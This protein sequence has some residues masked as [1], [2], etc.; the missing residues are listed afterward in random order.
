MAKN[1]PTAEESVQ[2]FS[3]QL[4]AVI[5]AVVKEELASVETRIADAG[6]GGGSVSTDELL[7][8]PAFSKGVNDCMEKAFQTVLPQLIKRFKDEVEERF[9]DFNKGG[10]GTGNVDVKSL[11]NS[12]AMK[13]MLDGRF[14]QMLLYL[15]Q[16]IIP[17][18][19]DQKISTTA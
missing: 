8:S 7:K 1:A 6:A 17:K 16:D 9:Q 18:A 3:D 13:E 2:G 19:I 14:R 10:G 12:E 11:A 4:V 5:R 15:K